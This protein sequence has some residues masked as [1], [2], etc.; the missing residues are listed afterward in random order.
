MWSVLTKGILIKLSSHIPAHNFDDMGQ[1][2]LGVW[3]MWSQWMRGVVF[4]WATGQ[5]FIAS[6]VCH[7]MCLP[8]RGHL[9]RWANS[10]ETEI[11]SADCRLM[12]APRCLFEPSRVSHWTA[13]APVG[14]PPLPH[15]EC[16]STERLSGGPERDVVC[17]QSHQ[18]V[19]CI[20]L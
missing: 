12:F 13:S 20:K 11:Y 14:L 6:S 16:F 19:E 5:S 8:D 18:P 1:L 15:P 3:R 2:M 4:L 7:A 9:A 17:T 10:G